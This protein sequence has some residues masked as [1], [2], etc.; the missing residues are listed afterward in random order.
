[1]Q[2]HKNSWFKLHALETHL[3][4]QDISHASPRQELKVRMTKVVH[5]AIL[6]Y[7]NM[8]FGLVLAQIFVH[9]Q[10]DGC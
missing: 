5:K 6:V 9:I 4:F 8:K 7:K 3:A 10:V 2:Q 1:M